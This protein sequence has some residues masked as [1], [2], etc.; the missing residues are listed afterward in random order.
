MEEN[1]KI[2]SVDE[3]KVKRMKKSIAWILG[4]IGIVV[5][6]SQVF[7]LTKS[8]V[9]G[10]FQELKQRIMKDPLPESYRQYI[11][12]E[13]AYYDPGK[14]YFANLSDSAEGLQYQGVFTYDPKTKTSKPI[15]VNKEYSENMYITID[16]IDI[17]DIRI[18]P[19]V[20]SSDEKVYDQYLKFGLAH[21]KGTP[22]PGDGGNSFIYGHSA[23][24]KFFSRH[25]NLPETI[26]TR[27]EGVDIGDSVSINKGG[28]ELKYIVRNKRIVSPDDF[29]ILKSQSDKETLTMM[30]C[31]PLGV[32][33]K[34]L[35]VVAERF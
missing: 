28:E 7:P 19:N 6:I 32:G 25:S 23:V 31:W 34:R 22:L 27:L 21:F 4:V 8:Y 30:T 2:S 29:S 20:E 33:T 13:F 17:K 12:D 35:V 11:A 15:V 26:F 10:E 14:S 16:K 18:T 3:K 24:E 9:Q 1:I 5:I